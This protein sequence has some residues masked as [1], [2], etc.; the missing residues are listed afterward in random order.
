[1]VLTVESNN[2]HFI[3]LCTEPFV[4]MA[5]IKHYIHNNTQYFFSVIQRIGRFG[6]AVSPDEIVTS[7]DQLTDDQ[8][9]WF[10]WWY[11]YYLE[12]KKE[13]KRIDEN[14]KPAGE[15]QDYD[16]IKFT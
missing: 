16:G 10:F 7:A 6:P 12:L 4:A 13:N 11:E 5:L 14:S 2:F 3:D 1:M 8:I 15:W 9:K